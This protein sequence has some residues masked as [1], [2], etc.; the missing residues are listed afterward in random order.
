MGQKTQ[1]CQEPHTYY[2]GH[3][4]GERDCNATCLL[5][6]TV[7]KHCY[8]RN[9]NNS[10]KSQEEGYHQE[11]GIS[12][13][14]L[15]R[16]C[17]ILLYKKA[18]HPR[19]FKCLISLTWQQEKIFRWRSS[20]VSTFCWTDLNLLLSVWY[21]CFLSHKTWKHKFIR[22]ILH[23]ECMSYSTSKHL[24]VFLFSQPVR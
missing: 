10:V 16:K 4:I 19:M 1:L 7:L 8:L 22:I 23:L 11:G 2:S 20:S 12:T 17:H 14:T 6:I 15:V 13:K 18:W 9:N 5:L 24:W 21:E 3:W